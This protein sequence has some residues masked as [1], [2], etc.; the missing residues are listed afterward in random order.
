MQIYPSNLP[1]KMG[2]PKTGAKYKHKSGHQKKVERG[3]KKERKERS[4]L[5][6]SLF[7]THENTCS[8]GHGVMK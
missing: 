2:R 3:N 8:D 5:K 7:V 6:I 4:Q 1:G